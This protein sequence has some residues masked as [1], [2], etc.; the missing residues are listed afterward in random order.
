M[1][2]DSDRSASASNSSFE[3]EDFS[4]PPSPDAGDNSAAQGPEPYQFEPMAQ[5]PTEAGATA[6]EADDALQGRMGAV[7]E[8]CACGHCSSLSPAE[9]ICCRETPK[10]WHRCQQVG[11]S[12]CITQHPGFELVSLN[13]YVLQAAYAYER[14]IFG[15]T[16]ETMVNSSYRHLAYRNFVRWCWGYLGQHIR[17]VL[18]SC[19]VT[20]IR[21]H[22]PEDGPYTG[23]LPPLDFY[24]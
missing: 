10:V 17:V 22:F 12:T 6:A 2:S 16:Q 20:V 15:E 21:E 5:A 19:A 14:Q 7:S 9:N 13:P 11:V 23:F 4:P 24:E 18:P 3:V 1:E 8:W